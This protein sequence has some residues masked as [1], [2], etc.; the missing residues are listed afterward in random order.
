MDDELHDKY[1]PR[2]DEVHK[3]IDG[4]CHQQGSGWWSGLVWRYVNNVEITGIVSVLCK[5]I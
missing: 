1:L 2:K 4:L 3:L 5:G